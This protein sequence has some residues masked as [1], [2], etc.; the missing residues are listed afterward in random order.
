MKLPNGDRAE[1]DERKLREYLLS[2]SHPVGR[3][4]AAF[5]ARVGF[6]SNNWRDLESELRRLAIEADAEPAQ[7]SVFGRKYLT[8]GTLVG[9]GGAAAPVVVVWIIPAGRVHPIDHQHAIHTVGLCHEFQRHHRERDPIGVRR[10]GDA[11]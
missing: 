8:L 2:P 4:K 1:I 11:R 7:P 5:F 6:T 10:L 9:P 3:F